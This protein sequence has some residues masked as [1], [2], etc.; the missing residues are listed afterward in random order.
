MARQSIE[1][2]DL[3]LSALFTSF[4]AVPDF[5]REYV[6]G[7]QQVEQ[8]L[9][10]IYDEFT[11][12]GRS[13]DSE[14]FIGS[15]VVCAGPDGVYDLIDGQQRMTTAYL[16]LC[17][18]R[19]YLKSMKPSAR[20]EA[21]GSQIS[22]SDVNER[23][24]DVFRFRV[25]L[26]YEDSC[27]VLHIIATGVKDPE[28][29]ERSTRSVENILNA[30]NTIKAFFRENFGDNAQ[31]LRRYYAY[32][33]RNVKLIRVNT[34]SLAHALKVFETINARGVGLDSMDLL[35]NL[36]FME[37][38]QRDYEQLKNEWKKLVDTLY[39]AGEKPLRFLRYFIFAN[40]DVERLREDGIYNWFVSN[41][42]LSG[43]GARSVEFVRELLAHAKAYANFIAGK[44][45]HGQQNRYLQNL[46]LLSGS[47]RQHLILLLAGQHLDEALFSE[48]CHQVENLYFAYVITRSDT[49]D[50]EYLFAKWAKEVRA[51]DSRQSLE[52]FI[53]Q[54]FLRERERLAARFD[55]AFEQLHEHAL[56]KYKLRYVLAKLA[57][58][59]DE[60]AWGSEGG[61]SELRHYIHRIEIE[62]ILPQTPTQDVIAAFDKPDEIPVYIRRLGNLTLLEKSINASIG[63]G[64]FA[65]KQQ[66]YSQSNMLLTKTIGGPVNVGVNT[67]VDRTVREL[68]E[69]TTWTSHDI[70]RR[71]AMLQRLA[72]RVWDMPTV[73]RTAEHISPNSAERG[74]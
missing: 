46:T 27:N 49:R 61:R 38:Q 42:Q 7:E 60:R 20:I 12:E 41:K 50:F 28:T 23:G 9:Q 3:T 36:M 67:S 58:N 57:Q 62:H 44:D 22:A 17:A 52:A 33:T 54:N 1:S 21:L 16:T 59:I 69:F 72:H 24:E 31:E 15:M 68:E 39:G 74:T 14:Y 71:Q 11:A 65:S 32:L 19:D 29:I 40:Y 34:V 48:L 10:D 13:D 2:Q 30:Y 73:A 37:A 4:Y 43:Y 51:I 26:Q 66:A 64:L 70:E 25:E 6:W 35:K 53:A 8:L 5:Q 45:I 18:I 55:L 47:A 63:N 56:Q